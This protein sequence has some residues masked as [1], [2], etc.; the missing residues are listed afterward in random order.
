MAG[1]TSAN[2]DFA[3]TIRGRTSNPSIMK[4][5]FAS[6][7]CAAAL[8]MAI[9]AHAQ[10]PAPDPW[11]SVRFL[12]GGWKGTTTGRPGEG[13]VVRKYEFVLGGRYLH[14]RN[15][16]TYPPQELNRKGEIHEHWSFFSYDRARKLLV[17]RQFHVEGFVNQYVFNPQESAPDKLVFESEGFENLSS[18]WRARE[19]YRI[20]GPDEFT[21]TFELAAPGKPFETYSTNIFKRDQVTR[22]P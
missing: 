10:E 11:A 21:E 1:A 12:E 19:S 5:I 2:T 18:K 8:A 17:M 4:P 16:S 20:S 14:E 6:I 7:A 9:P 15:T 13:T 3:L 22:S